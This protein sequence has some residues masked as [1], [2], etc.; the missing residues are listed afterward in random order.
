MMTIAQITFIALVFVAL[1]FVA[2]NL[3]YSL[4]LLLSWRG[5]R[6]RQ[7]EM[8]DAVQTARK[9]SALASTPS[10]TL[11][12]PAYNEEKC[13]LESTAS[14]LSTSANKLEV[15]VV[16]DGSKDQTCATLIAHYQM[17]PVTLR[18][19][20]R[21]STARVVACYESKLDPRLRLIRQENRG[22]AGALNTGIDYAMGDIVCTVDA[23]TVLETDSILKVTAPFLN[24]PERVLAASGVVRIANGCI[25]EN[26]HVAQ[27]RLPN[28]PV[29][30]FQII[31]Y[32][33]AFYCG[34]VG[35][36]RLGASILLSGAFSAFK[37]SA[38]VEVG[39]FDEKS[40]TEDLE[41]V[42]RLRNHYQATGRPCDI[43]LLSEPMCW[44]QAPTTLRMLWKQRLRW[45]Q[46][47][48]SSMLKHKRMV[49]NPRFG[50]VGW[51]T[52]PYMVVFEW[53]G[54]VIELS[55]YLV[56][57]HQFATDFAHSGNLALMLLGAA[58]YSFILTVLAILLA[59][60]QFQT[61]NPKYPRRINYRLVLFA[62]LE[63]FGYRQFTWLSRLYG[64]LKAIHGKQEWGTQDRTQMAAP[65]PPE[66]VPN[67]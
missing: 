22:K 10:V 64:F 15:L 34:R 5:M 13:I 1:G 65:Q 24:A 45:Q 47:L 55:G 42:L 41:I 43:I 3:S 12:V 8:T 59:H 57:I 60:T 33:R 26:H 25:F 27:G 35:W 62:F 56:L 51:V 37:K 19:S 2:A 20:N 4:L 50:W 53:F 23:D 48:A 40:L 39:G 63:N 30:M 38:L 16:D 44:T 61:H 17:E 54:P 6:R 18:R 31:E 14:F 46:G 32:I 7:Q 49:L 67:T 21:V 36:N 52:L 58:V 29:V 28:D 9:L 66:G 11:I